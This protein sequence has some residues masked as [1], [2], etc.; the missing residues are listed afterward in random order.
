M[1]HDTTRLRL[2]TRPA[3]KDIEMGMKLGR[4]G[5]SQ[6]FR[7]KMTGPVRPRDPPPPP[8]MAN[9]SSK[10]SLA[11]KLFSFNKTEIKRINRFLGISDTDQSRAVSASGV[12]DNIYDIA[13]N[14]EHVSELGVTVVDNSTFYTI[15][16]GTRAPE[17]TCPGPEVLAP[18][19][20]ASLKKNISLRLRPRS[21]EFSAS[22]DPVKPPRAKRERSKSFTPRSNPGTVKASIFNRSLSQVPKSSSNSSLKNVTATSS[23]DPKKIIVHN[24]DDERHETKQR[25][26]SSSDLVTI[27]PPDDERR[28]FKDI[29]KILSSPSISPSSLSCSSSS[30]S[31][32]IYRPKSQLSGSSSVINNSIMEEQIVSVSTN[33]KPAFAEHIYEEIR[34]NAAGLDNE[35]QSS[36]RPLPPL[37]SEKHH[38]RQSPSRSSPIISESSSPVK[39]I[40]EGASKYDILNYLEDARER[41]L[42]DCDLDIDEEEEDGEESQEEEAPHDNQVDPEAGV[43]QETTTVLSS[44]HR[45]H[46]HRVS[47]ISTASSQDNAEDTIEESRE[48]REKE[49][50]S[51]VDIERNDSG[52]GSETGRSRSVSKVVV[53]KRS[54][55]ESEELSCL[56]CDAILGQHEGDK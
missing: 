11:K 14:D 45:N 53:R 25:T 23:D 42:T 19:P 4:L 24:N 1:F 35:Q 34:D 54:E 21:N 13:E 9:D 32:Q 8:P 29:R 2:K 51:A 5:V 17:V 36:K 6:S 27:F 22:P 46:N 55:Q 48:H 7:E 44:P 18:R 28:S 12:G 10:Y 39:S 3:L 30:S 40:F 31:S 16:T 37:P 33:N 41:G 43:M 50:L 47:H 49:K 38:Q 56:D 26:F 15:N 20:G 52:L